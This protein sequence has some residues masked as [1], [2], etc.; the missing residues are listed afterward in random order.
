[1]MPNI[2]NEV[3]HII[4]MPRCARHVI[5]GS[6]LGLKAAVGWWRHDSR[7]AYHYKGARLPEKT[8]EAN[9]VPTLV[10]KQRLVLTSATKVVSTFGPD[11]GHVQ[12]PDTGLIIASP[13]I[14]AH[15]MLSLSWLLENYRLTPSRPISP[16]SSGWSRLLP[17]A[18]RYY[19]G[20]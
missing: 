15:D 3:D 1:M 20:P 11:N 13:S 7:L 16:S 2:V 6:T 19:T 17:E 18:R 4:L 12:V 5:A 14:V 9:L 8:A 10:D